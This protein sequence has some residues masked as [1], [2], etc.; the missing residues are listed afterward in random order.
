MVFRCNLVSLPLLS[1]TALLVV[2]AF[3]DASPAQPNKTKQQQGKTN[4]PAKTNPPGKDSGQQA[5]MQLE[6]A[7]VLR[8]AYLL[9]LEGNADYD[10]HRAKAMTAVKHAFK[11]LDGHVSKHGGP[12]QKQVMKRENA[13]ITAAEKARKNAGILQEAQAVSD[14]RLGQAR[15]ILVGLRPNLAN[16]A[17]P[18]ILKHVN[19]AILE[20]TTALK[21][22]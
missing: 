3:P 22:R 16:H 7:E 11:A 17:Q 2:L 4:P 21:V 15:E 14:A 19:T 13:T 8:R 1:T 20:I 9:L 12:Q 6:E 5:E 10:G 18:E